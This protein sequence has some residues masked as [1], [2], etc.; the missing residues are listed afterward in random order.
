[1]GSLR[2]S[3]S[4]FGPP[5][6]PGPSLLGRSSYPFVLVIINL[7][8]WPSWTF[9]VS[10]VLAHLPLFLSSPLGPGYLVLLLLTLQLLVLVP[11]VLVLLVPLVHLFSCPGRPVPCPPCTAPNGS[12]PLD[13]SSPCSG[14][15]E[16][17]Y[18]GPGPPGQFCPLR[19][20]FLTLVGLVTSDLPHPGPATQGDQSAPLGTPGPSP[21]CPD[22]YGPLSPDS[23][24]PDHYS[25]SPSSPPGSGPLDALS[26]R[27]LS[28]SNPCPA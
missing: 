19:L 23:G 3:S 9:L 7:V 27:S 8:F 28:P 12:G 18:F 1:M 11:Q 25:F 21:L 13:P 22:L 26:L 4:R 2:H 6:H 5:S 14:H 15:P 20:D 10:P 24:S 17:G 16:P